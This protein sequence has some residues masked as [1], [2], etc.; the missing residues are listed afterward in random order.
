VFVQPDPAQAHEQWRKVADGFR[1]RFP[2]LATLMDDAEDEVL[3]YLAFPRPHWRQIWSPNPREMA[4][5]Q[6]TIAA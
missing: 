4:S 2:R 6:S 1:P 5:S 3:A